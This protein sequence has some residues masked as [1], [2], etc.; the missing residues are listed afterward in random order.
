MFTRSHPDYIRHKDTRYKRVGHHGHSGGQGQQEEI[1]EQDQVPESVET[2]FGEELQPLHSFKN[3]ISKPFTFQKPNRSGPVRAQCGK[4]GAGK[5]K[6]GKGQRE[7]EGA[8]N[9]HEGA[10]P[11]VSGPLGLQT[12]ILNH[13]CGVSGQSTSGVNT[14]SSS[15]SAEH[16]GEVKC[17]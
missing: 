11:T 12:S 2:S 16:G 6:S 15:S 14:A 7:G 1:K 5:L 13:N 9:H 17:F 3:L 10:Q 8:R 4:G